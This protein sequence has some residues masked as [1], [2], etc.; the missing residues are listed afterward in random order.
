ME[1]VENLT[2]GS[3]FGYLDRVLKLSG[4]RAGA[5][6]IDVSIIESS[7]MASERGDNAKPEPNVGGGQTGNRKREKRES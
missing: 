6:G 5:C 7:T 4:Y 2:R 1:S 3:K